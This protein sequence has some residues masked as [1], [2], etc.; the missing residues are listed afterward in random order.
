MG[1]SLAAVLKNHA[2]LQALRIALVQG[3]DYGKIPGCGDKPTLLKPGAEKVLQRFSIAVSIKLLDDLSTPDHPRYRVT[4]VGKLPNGL[5]V[6]EGLGEASGAEEKYAWRGTNNA[7][8]EHTPAE[9]RRIKHKTGR[10]GDYA[11]KQVRTNPADYLN[12]VLKMAAKRAKV[13]LALTATAASQFFTQDLEDLSPEMQ[14]AVEAERT[15]PT[16][17]R[18]KGFRSQ[19]NPDAPPP[20]VDTEAVVMAAPEECKSVWFAYCELQEWNPDSLPKGGVDQYREWVATH[21]G[22]EAAESTQNW[23]R[24]IAEKLQAQIRVELAGGEPP[25]DGGGADPNKVPF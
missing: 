10:N 18:A 5:E 16:S 1:G 2:A 23:T 8:W 11:V 14:A 20:P 17:D 21:A 24:E 4:V 9:L 7:E 6:G 3:T 22:R 15:T 13:D 25:A 19:V 12:T